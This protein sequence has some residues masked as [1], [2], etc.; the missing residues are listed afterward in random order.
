MYGVEPK[1]YFRCKVS[2]WDWE[3]RSQDNS[4]QLDQATDASAY[5][6]KRLR[7]KR[8]I[9]IAYTSRNKHNFTFLAAQKQES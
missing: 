5:T 8:Q 3:K 2:D 9:G 7:K 4:L 6:T 1:I